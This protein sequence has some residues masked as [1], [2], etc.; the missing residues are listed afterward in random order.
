MNN[1]ESIEWGNQVH[2][3][4]LM[5]VPKDDIYTIEKVA[6][7]AG[8]LCGSI[9][10]LSALEALTFFVDRTSVVNSEDCACACCERIAFLVNGE[11]P[12]CRH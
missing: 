9:C 1:S 5:G 2:R 12:D 11:C 3:L 7:T 4:K 10:R 8:M 6:E